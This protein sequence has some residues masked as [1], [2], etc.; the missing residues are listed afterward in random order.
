M[1]GMMPHRFRGWKGQADGRFRPYENAFAHAKLTRSPE[2]VLEV[3]LHANGAAQSA[4]MR[5]RSS[6]ARIIQFDARTEEIIDA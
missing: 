2:G 5:I 6:Y 3:V 1:P 4:S